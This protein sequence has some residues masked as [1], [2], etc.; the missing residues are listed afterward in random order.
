MEN[1]LTEE[2]ML[3]VIASQIAKNQCSY[4]S[5]SEEEKKELFPKVEMVA[6]SQVDELR[7][8]FNSI[9]NSVGVPI[10]PEMKLELLGKIRDRVKEDGISSFMNAFSSEEM[11]N[12][13][14][15]EAIVVDQR[16]QEIAELDGDGILSSAIASDFTILSPNEMEAKE[17][18]FQET[19]KWVMPN[20]LEINYVKPED[21]RFACT[22]K[23]SIED[24]EILNHENDLKI[25]FA[26]YENNPT[27]EN[28]DK[29]MECFD[30]VINLHNGRDAALRYIESG[31]NENGIEFL[32]K[33]ALGKGLFK[34]MS[35][36]LKGDRETGTGLEDDNYTIFNKIKLFSI[37]NKEHK[38]GNISDNDFRKF[39][40]QMK[41]MDPELYEKI[42]KNP[43]LFETL[44]KNMFDKNDVNT[45]DSNNLAIKFAGKSEAITREETMMALDEF[46]REKP[47]CQKEPTGEAPQPVRENKVIEAPPPKKQYIP[48]ANT[49][50]TPKEMI[51]H[52]KKVMLRCY[53]EKG[54]E[55]VLKALLNN[56]TT[57]LLPPSGRAGWQEAIAG[58]LDPEKLGT[59][60]SIIRTE[61]DW[62][63]LKEHIKSVCK[64]EKAHIYAQKIGAATKAISDSEK[65]KKM[66]SVGPVEEIVERF[67]GDSNKFNGK[68]ESDIEEGR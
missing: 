55:N 38:K 47:E 40:E 36:V 15:S 61:E 41:D 9:L 12:Y 58:L 54:I 62:T 1:G 27:P 63:A 59:E 33:N 57:E 13:I 21:S 28:Y 64:D 3:R 19:H 45:N 30:L 52:H 49:V 35:I 51:E 17:A 31:L 68:Q 34:K 14:S 25:I 5:K 43:A 18:E 20:G 16:L 65:E 29:C 56:C 7:K 24:M 46:V 2:E 8:K 26:A 48:P 66:F 6:N 44:Q 10:V 4:D 67:S 11:I 60:E 22:E 39:E 50:K 32:T 23:Q 37:I 42:E 53:N